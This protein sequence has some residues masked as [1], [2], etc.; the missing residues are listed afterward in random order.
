ME[1]RVVREFYAPDCT[2]GRML[3]DGQFEC[4]TLE[5]GIRTNKVAGETAIPAGR[6]PVKITY[7]NAFRREL[8][9]VEGVRNFTGIRIHS[10]NSKKDTLGCILVGQSWTPGADVIGA[11]VRAM[12]ALLPKIRAALG[13]G[14]AVTLSVEQPNAPP[15]LASRE[16]QPPAPR[17][18]KKAAKTAKRASQRPRWSTKTSH[19]HTPA[20][21]A[22]PPAKQ[23]GATTRSSPPAVK[24]TAAGKAEVN[25]KAKVKAKDKVKAKAAKRRP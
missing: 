19:A 24:G 13:A 1:L 9:L 20:R 11:S 17:R 25:A 8:P 2:I 4:Y 10:G 6:Y 5:D 12:Q 15:E 18:G 3:I 7:S 14:E 16:L 23:A 22:R 21:K